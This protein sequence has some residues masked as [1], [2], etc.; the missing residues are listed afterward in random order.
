[1]IV[2]SL[3][4]IS[5]LGLL[6]F[7][8][9]DR[10]LRAYGLF[11]LILLFFVVNKGSLAESET[12]SGESQGPLDAL[13]WLLLGALLFVSLR[14]KQ[15]RGFRIDAV[16]SVLVALFGLD[17]LVSTAYAED[18]RYSLL[19]AL[20]YLL[21]LVAVIVGALRYL[22][23]RAKCLQFFRFHYYVAMSLLPLPLL[24]HFIGL[25][26]YGATVLNGQYA[27][28]FGNQNLF[29]IFS[30]LITPYVLFHWN[31]ETLSRRDRIIDGTLLAVIFVGLWLSNS[32]G[33]LLATLISVGTYF[34]IVNLESR[35]KIMV[36]AILLS[37]AFTLFPTVKSNV[38]SFIRKD[39]IER[40]EITDVTTQILEE[41]RYVLWKGVWPIYWDAKMT[42]YGFATSHLLAF[43]FSGDKVA[44]RH[45]HNSY[46]EL[47]GD[48]GLPGIG[49][50]LLIFYRMLS[51]GLN[52]IQRH[53]GYLQRNINAV[54][55]AVFMAGL[56][57][58]FFE[59]WMFSVGNIISLMCWLPISGIVAQWAWAPAPQAA[60]QP[61]AAMPRELQTSAS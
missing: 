16:L 17:I 18:T 8:F 45:V 34:F 7:R 61:A 53:E 47:F 60:N 4:V 44:G 32:R 28:P 59:S 21:L 51:C 58:A 36:S 25:G 12:L 11:F 29:G 49:L 26:A 27:G 33:G 2:A 52:L 19:R 6:Y 22:Y 39:T 40:A 20:S 57:N 42:G 37:A 14:E 13:R 46:L 54:F 23:W 41:R 48:L 43:P 31:V 9:T 56:V 50:L 1:M 5:V 35:L 55:L 38:M 30:A 10:F 24:L 3:L 15:Q